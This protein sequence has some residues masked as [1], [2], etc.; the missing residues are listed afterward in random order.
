MGSRPGLRRLPPVDYLKLHTGS[1]DSELISESVPQKLN[2]T[3][4]AVV[5]PLLL[6]MANTAV[7]ENDSEVDLD[8]MDDEA[9]DRTIQEL[10]QQEA[11]I[12]RRKK[13]ETIKDLREKINSDKHS[14][15]AK[16]RSVSSHKVG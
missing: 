3:S 4:E 9:L 10:V 16:K 12:E 2:S 1:T 7:S 11:L 5:V 15:T 8:D 13:I 14:A 6:E